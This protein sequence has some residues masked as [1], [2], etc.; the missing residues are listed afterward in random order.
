M[1]AEFPAWSVEDGVFPVAEEDRLR[2]ALSASGITVHRFR[3]HEFRH[4]PEITTATIPRGSCYFVQSMS[5][6]PGWPRGVFGNPE[7]FACS[8][9]FPRFGPRLV[10]HAARFMSLGELCWTQPTLAR[11]LGGLDGTLFIRPDDGFKTFEGR[12]VSPAAFEDWTR[13]L[14][15]LQV[16]MNTRIVVGPSISLQREWRIAAIDGRAIA[17]SEYKP[18]WAQ[19]APDG[20]LRFAEEC[21][22]GADWRIRAC[23]VDVAQTDAGLRIVEVGSLLC[24]AW[25]EADPVQILNAVNRLLS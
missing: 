17:A 12:L 18:R 5:A 25:Y 6:E 15:M 1:T 2:T 20:V 23:S 19:G 11:E 22:R 9:Y 7:D 8:S 24:V 16:P 13:Q 14:R 3:A 4:H 10:N 21:L